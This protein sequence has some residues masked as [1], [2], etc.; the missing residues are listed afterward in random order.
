M[1]VSFRST[2]SFERHP[3]SQSH[4]LRLRLCSLRPQVGCTQE[5]GSMRPLQEPKLECTE[6]KRAAGQAA[7]MKYRVRRER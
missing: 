2:F 3:C 6:G 1:F 4:R 5:A 7:R